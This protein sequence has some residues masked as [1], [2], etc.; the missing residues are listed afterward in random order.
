M[1]RSEAGRTT[2]R[3]GLR[4]SSLVEVMVCLSLAGVVFASIAT[5]FLSS[6]RSNDA[7]AKY[8]I[9]NALVRDR[10]EQLLSLRFADPRLSE[11]LHEDDLPPTVPDPATG[12]SP[13]SIRNV[14]RRTYRVR[15]FALPP[16]DTVPPGRPFTPVPVFGPG[17]RYDYKQLDVTVELAVSRPGFGWIGARVSAIRF[18]PAPQEIP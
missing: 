9:A 10:L 7:A 16:N 15:H 8:S 13:S 6:R 18:N 4:G 5:L 11:G 17:S 1:T 2:K 3:Q 14:F 12:E